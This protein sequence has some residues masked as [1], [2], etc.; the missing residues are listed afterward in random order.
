MCFLNLQAINV[1]M[2]QIPFRVE[3]DIKGNNTKQPIATHNTIA[4]N[5]MCDSTSQRKC[6]YLL[7]AES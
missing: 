7:C 1:K 2:T 3:Y 5:I 4:D 6:P